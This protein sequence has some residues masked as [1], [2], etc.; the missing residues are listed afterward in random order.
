M[1]DVSDRVQQQQRATHFKQFTLKTLFFY[2]KILF[3]Y[4]VL[5]LRTQRFL[6]GMANFA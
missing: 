4:I 2:R 6:Q 1:F 3:L 5:S